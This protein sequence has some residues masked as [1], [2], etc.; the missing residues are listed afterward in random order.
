MNETRTETVEIDKIKID[1]DFNPRSDFDER[2]LTE[3]EASIRQ[4][5]LVTAL[6]VRPNGDGYVLIAGQRRLIAAKR[7]GLE[8]VPVV[9]REGTDALAAAI[10]ENLIRADL[11]P[12]EEANA[13]AR[14]AEAEKLATH[15]QLAERVGKSSA[16]VSER[17]RLLALPEAAQLQIA[18]GKVPVAAE[19]ELRKA[20]EVS[21]AIAECA[22]KLVARGEIEGRDL[23]ER[24]DEVLHAVAESGLR[25][26]PA[27]VEVGHGVLLSQLVADP[28]QHKALAERINATQRYRDEEDPYLHL[29]EAEVDAARAAGCLLEYEVEREGWTARA[30]YLCDAELAA[31]I[32]VRAVERLEKEAAKRAKQL[33][34]EAGSN[35]EV[36]S[37]EEVQERVSRERRE[38]REE[39]KKE[40]IRARTF[41]LDLGRKLVARRG[42][43]T[44]KEHSLARARAL[45]E[46]VLA[47]NPNL[48]ARG[49]RLVL[50]Q[51]QEVETK[52]LKSGESRETVSYHDAPACEAYLRNRIEEARTPNEILELLADALVAALSADERELAQS[53][54][55]HWWAPAGERIEKLLAA[56]AKSVRP[57][58]ARRR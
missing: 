26:K 41:N 12:I 18:A 4:T 48:A 42:A 8:T 9:V 52:T 49:L 58:R 43:A 44:R 25:E 11:D 35:G 47:D 30:S 37:T 7:A 20:A 36:E 29:A 51:L 27:M 24:F 39:A 22:C 17:L 16:Y 45:A 40:A 3:L 38:G 46:L 13:L 33:A 50:P 55:I 54:R 15:K 19:R 34:S 21:P 6:T 28:A 53:R 31:D 32:A 2:S 57:G 23:M 10:A 5:G 56:D 14:I 1:E